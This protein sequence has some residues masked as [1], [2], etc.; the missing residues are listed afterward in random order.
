MSLHSKCQLFFPLPDHSHYWHLYYYSLLHTF[1]QV[2]SSTGM[3]SP[4]LA[5]RV[6]SNFQGLNESFSSKSLPGS[7]S[8]CLSRTTAGFAC[9]DAFFLF[10][11][12]T[13][14]LFQ[15]ALV[16]LSN[17]VPS[18]P[19]PSIPTAKFY[20]TAYRHQ[21]WTCD[22]NE[23]K[24]LSAGMWTAVLSQRALLLCTLEP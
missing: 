10:M 6:L 20:T 9:P 17:T 11:V 23:S 13:S 19:L 21:S 7:Y 12:S 5:F 16:G 24:R 14:L 22:P 2:V 8:R 18:S 4:N 3:P 15:M 1:A